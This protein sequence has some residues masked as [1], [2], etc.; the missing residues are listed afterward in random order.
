MIVAFPLFEAVH[1]WKS[2]PS[3]ATRSTAL[4][5]GCELNDV[6]TAVSD[7][8]REIITGIDVNMNVICMVIDEIDIWWPVRYGML[9]L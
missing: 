3:Y 6:V 2:V 4:V 1:P 9:V 7:D 5:R 8:N